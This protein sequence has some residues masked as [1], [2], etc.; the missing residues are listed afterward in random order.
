MLYDRKKALMSDVLEI[1]YVETEMRTIP[2]IFKRNAILVFLMKYLI[3][4]VLT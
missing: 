4:H 1:C 3:N 2:M